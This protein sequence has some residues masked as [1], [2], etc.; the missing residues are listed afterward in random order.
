MEKIT[1]TAQLR[2]CGEAA[3][4]F[5][6]GLVGELAATVAEALAELE[7][8]K[9]DKPQAVSVVLPASGWASDGGDYPK[10]YDIP[11]PGEIGRAHV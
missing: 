9:A 3:K 11:V 10:Y 4:G 8:A 6:S 1:I 2:A 7:N 5:V